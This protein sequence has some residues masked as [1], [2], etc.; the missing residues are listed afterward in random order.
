M[1]LLRAYRAAQ[2]SLR[3]SGRVY[4]GEQQ[5]AIA[6]ES[7]GMS[8]REAACIVDEWMFERPLKHLSRHGAHRLEPLLM[9]LDERGLQLGVLSDYEAHRKLRALGVAHYFSRVLC[10]ADPGV[11]ALKPDPRGLL[12]ACAGWQLDPPAVVMIGDRVEVDAAAAA[13]AGMRSI[14]VGRR[15]RD[16]VDLRTTFVSSLEQVPS[17]LDDCC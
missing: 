16:Y 13:A 10:A 5:I 4:D 17:V 11:R 3:S 9:S 8:S 12:L 1:R 6:A 15:P 2:E 7:A 14:I